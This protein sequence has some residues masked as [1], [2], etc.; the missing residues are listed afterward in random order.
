MNISTLD[1]YI[2]T[3]S[4][5]YNYIMIISTIKYIEYKKTDP[6]KV[7][8]RKIQPLVLSE[9]VVYICLETRGFT[10]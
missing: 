1:I 10:F 6:K 2:M 9:E 7:W 3:I 5:F 4:T 8:T